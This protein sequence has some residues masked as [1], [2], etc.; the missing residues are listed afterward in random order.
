[1]GH[2]YH[3]YVTNSQSVLRKIPSSGMIISWRLLPKNTKNGFQP[4]EKKYVLHMYIYIYT[5]MYVFISL[6]IYL[7]VY[8]Y[9]Y[10]QCIYLFTCLFIYIYIS[11]IT[12]YVSHLKP[13]QIPTWSMLPSA[14]RAASSSGCALPKSAKLRG[15]YLA[16]GSWGY[17]GFPIY[18]VDFMENIW[19]MENKKVFPG[20]SMFSIFFQCT[21]YI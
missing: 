14:F 2:L 11:R 4:P 21:W 7:C 20:K 5:V 1:M 17:L 9:I 18:L 3:G 19:F 6:F 8:I 15:V 13:H 10:I 12:P 16:G